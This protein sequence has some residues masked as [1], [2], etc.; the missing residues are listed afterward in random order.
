MTDT[1]VVETVEAT[2]ISTATKLV[3]LGFKDARTKGSLWNVA[4]E[5]IMESNC[6]IGETQKEQA[7]AFTDHI[8]KTVDSESIPA[9]VKSRVTGKMMDSRNEDGSYK[10][11]T[12]EGSG[13]W[14]KAMNEITAGVRK[15]SEKL[16]DGVPVG[17][18]KAKELIF[19][20]GKVVSG[21]KIREL[22]GP[23]E[24]DAI[25]N[26]ERAVV[27]VE[28]MLPNINMSADSERFE[29]A[30]KRIVA[31]FTSAAIKKAA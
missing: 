2:P 21:R 4:G 29:A 12:M 6:L 27:M 7:G 25:A 28:N 24:I 11:S 26:I 18:E 13:G 9:K 8:N 19:P 16:E 3:R 30:Y 5:L 22:L 1:T 20:K 23:K 10:W 31:A 14:M 17:K 15:L